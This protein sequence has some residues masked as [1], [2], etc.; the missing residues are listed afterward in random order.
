[1]SSHHYQ[2]SKFPHKIM[3]ARRKGMPNPVANKHA[4][5]NLFVQKSQKNYI[6]FKKKFWGKFYILFLNGNI[7]EKKCSLLDTL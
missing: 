2:R 4:K 6:F 7:T 1:M 3:F 5:I